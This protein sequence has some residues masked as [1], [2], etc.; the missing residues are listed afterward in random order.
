MLSPDPC[1]QRAMRAEKSEATKDRL[2][3]DRRNFNL[4]V[5]RHCLGLS[6]P[7][8]ASASSAYFSSTL[9]YS[10]ETFEDPVFVCLDTEGYIGSVREIGLTILDSR[11]LNNPDNISD[12]SRVLESHNYIVRKDLK[13][14]ASRP[15]NFGTSQRMN[16]RWSGW[17]LE[18]V[19]R[20]GSPDPARTE[21]RNVILVGDS[22]FYDLHGL[23]R[24]E[25]GKLD[26]TSIPDVP[27]IDTADLAYGVF[28]L[29]PWL[30]PG[31]TELIDWLEI[32]SK[33]IT[34]HNAGNDA[35]ATMK[36]ML[37]LALRSYEKLDLKD[38]DE[39]RANM[40]RHIVRASSPVSPM[41]IDCEDYDKLKDQQVSDRMGD[42]VDA[43]EG[44]ID[45]E[46]MVGELEI[47][48]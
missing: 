43:C 2:R 27:V 5:L 48:S 31:L 17:L 25:R 22:I 12:W 8:G 18:K 41:E 29:Q 35:N 21:P 38:K 28:K 7:Q 36:V 42:W 6:S 24:T 32:E 39:D 14:E 47:E 23:A 1:L 3:H 45:L 20:T 16:R 34:W 13:A 40:L 30:R 9:S 46:N 19:L 15:F 10:A 4:N 26:F 44:G 33:G 37:M 11:N